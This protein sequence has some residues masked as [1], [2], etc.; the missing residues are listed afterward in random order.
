MVRERYHNAWHQ[1]FIF[2]YYLAPAPHLKWL[3]LR[4]KL[5]LLKLYV[6]H[7]D[8]DCKSEFTMP[9]YLDILII[10]LKGKDH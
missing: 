3:L 10:L 5:S 6:I 8:Y 9:I 7:E 4:V 2:S 1:L